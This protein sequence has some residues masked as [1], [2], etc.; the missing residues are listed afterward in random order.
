MGRNVGFKKVGWYGMNQKIALGTVQFGLP[1][2]VANAGGQ[3]TIEQV[4][5]VLA[6]ARQLGVDTIDTA[7]NYGT[8]EAVLGKI[9]VSDFRVISK[10]PAC[11][12]SEPDVEA[13]VHASLNSSL[14]RLGI[15]R[16]YGILLH[17]PQDLNRPQGHLIY[18]ALQAA[19]ERGQVEKMGISVYRPEDLAEFL[20]R[21]EFGLIQAPL[22]VFDRRLHE[23]GWLNR[24]N[25]AG[26]E[27]HVRSVFL[28]GLLLMDVEKRPVFFNQWQGVWDKWDRWLAVSNVTPLEACL[29]F[30]RSIPGVSRIVAGVVD[31]AQL[32]ELCA[33]PAHRIDDFPQF[34]VGPDDDLINPAKWRLQ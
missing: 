27:V 5:D 29:S 22:N 19:V 12:E 21:F 18:R 28:Q 2:G 11:P 32:N 10:L 20:A 16:F 31:S 8:S 13:W 6:S 17:R 15:S 23:S 3:P 34:G 14:Q 30:A 9:G 7:I 24:L 1:Y 33:D 25:E 26:I 4:R